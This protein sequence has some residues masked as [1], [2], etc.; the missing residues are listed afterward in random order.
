MLKEYLNTILTQEY[1]T[2][3]LYLKTMGIHYG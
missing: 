2:V 1:C 3:C